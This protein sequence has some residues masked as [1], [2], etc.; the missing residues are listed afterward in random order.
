M[1]KLATLAVC[2]LSMGIL[3]FASAAP[4]AKKTAGVTCPACKKMGMSMPMTAK[5]N[6]VNTRAVKVNGKTMYCCTK[7]NMK[8]MKT[9]KAPMKKM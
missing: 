8:T 4:V 9:S 2:G 6:K 1:R 7:C 3:G 5:K